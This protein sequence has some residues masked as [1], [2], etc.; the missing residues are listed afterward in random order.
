M[1]TISEFIKKYNSFNSETAKQNYLKGFLKENYAPLINKQTVLQLSLDRSIIKKDGI[2]YINMLTNK[3]NF[4]MSIMVL[5]TNIIAEKD[6]DGKTKTYEFYDL[7]LKNGILEKIYEYIGK[8]ELE[9]LVN[10]NKMLIDTFHE[11]NSTFAAYA[12]RI[13]DGLGVALKDI[14]LSEI[15]DRRSD[16]N[17]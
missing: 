4:I 5:Y 11:E 8:A 2:L 1:I 14:D 12:S 16:L 13:I 7:V 9:E 3:I 10:V 6:S 15:I 17:E